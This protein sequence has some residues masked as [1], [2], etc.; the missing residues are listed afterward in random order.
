MRKVVFFLL[1]GILLATGAVAL[2]AAQSAVEPPEDC[3]YCGMN[4]TTFAYS[5]MLVEYEDGTTVGTCSI[6][7]TAR[8]LLEN[9]EK[10]VRSV[11]VGDYRTRQLVDA[12]TATW[13]IGGK[14]SGVMSR[15]AKWAF[16]EQKDAQSFVKKHGGK[17]ATYEAALV[18]AKDDCTGAKKTSGCGNCCN[19]KKD[20]P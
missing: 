7:C 12:T 14:K 6:S 2:G 18:A 9:K 20:K 11:Q 13:V 8:N 1:V 4:R 3:L 5:R 17:I 16:A 19:K 15:V 10:Q